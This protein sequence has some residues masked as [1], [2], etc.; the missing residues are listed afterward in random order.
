MLAKL[1]TSL[2]LWLSFAVSAEQSLQG[3]VVTITD[4]DTVRVLDAAQT[5]HRVRLSG[6]DAPESGQAFGSR[7][8][9]N[10]ASLVG[11]QTL[12]VVWQKR[13]RYGR[14]VG[15]LVRQDGSDANLE[16]V[17]AGMAWW[18]REYAQEQPVADRQS[19]EAAEAEARTQ[20]RG[21]WRDPSPVPPWEFRRNKAPH[22]AP[23]AE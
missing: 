9:Q 8:R 14:I 13:D 21:L 22:P 20:G 10:L 16:Q 1:F 17:R 5:E 23:R 3:R 15:K 7:S 12:T 6:I 2:L 19:Y 11:G 18:Y 4:G